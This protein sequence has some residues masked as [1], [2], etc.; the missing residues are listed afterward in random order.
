MVDVLD[1]NGKVIFR[2]LYMSKAIEFMGVSRAH[3]SQLT[4][5]VVKYLTK[6]ANGEYLVYRGEKYG[7]KEEKPLY[8]EGYTFTYKGQDV[9]VSE[10]REVEFGYIYE[11][12]YNLEAFVEDKIK[13]YNHLWITYKRVLE[14]ND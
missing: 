12:N 2:S 4:S 10:I 3:I 14:K 13:T 5:G 8:Q 6:N 7:K 9:I 1:K 11:F